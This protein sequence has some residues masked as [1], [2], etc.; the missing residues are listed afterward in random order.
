MHVKVLYYPK[1][2]GAISG[3]NIHIYHKAVAN[4]LTIS[5]DIDREVF[6]L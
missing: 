3:E 1:R 5:I 2:L 4:L 6:A